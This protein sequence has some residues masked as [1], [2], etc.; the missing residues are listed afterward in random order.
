VLTI[1]LLG[2]AH[3]TLHGRTFPISAK[4]VALIT[5]LALEKVPQHRERLADLLWNTA[6]ARK[7]LRVELA[8]I[9]STGLN[10]FPASRQLLYL[11]NVVT[12]FELWRDRAGDDMNEIELSSWLTMLRGLPLSGLEDLGN[13]SFQEWVEQQRWMISQQVEQCLHSAYRRYAR[14]NHAWATRMIAARAE[15]LGLENPAGHDT[16]EAPAPTPARP[17]PAPTA[18]PEPERTARKGILHFDRPREEHALTASLERARTVPQA[19]IVHGEPGCGKTYLAEW[20]ARQTDA[21]TIRVTSTASAR[22]TIATL[23]QA[24]LHETDAEYASALTRVLLNPG[25]LDEDVVKVGAALASVRKPVLVMLD[26]VHQA[27]EDVAPLLEFLLRTPGS[28]ARAFLLLSREQPTHAPVT[29]LLAR[30]LDRTRYADVPLPPLTLAGVQR[31]LEQHFP[32]EPVKR[33]HVHANRLLQ[34][35]NGNP[36]RLLSLL[37]QG[38]DPRNITYSH[39][40]QL[41]RDKYEAETATWAKALHDAMSTLSVIVGSF[42]RATAHAALAAPEASDADAIIAEAITQRILAEVEPDATLQWPTLDVTPRGT[43]S[44]PQLMFT[45]EGLRVSLAGHLP[46]LTRRAICARLVN[47]YRQHQ[48]GLAAYYAERAGQSDEA[49]RLRQAYATLLP[50]GSPLRPDT[51]VLPPVSARPTAAEPERTRARAPR[52]PTTHNGYVIT[53]EDGQWLNIRSEGRYGHPAT[54]RVHLPLPAVNDPDAELTLTWRLDVYGD[55]RE[56]AP[57][58]VPFPL[59]LHAVGT[60]RAHVLTPHPTPSYAEDGIQHLVEDDAAVGTW[61]EYRLKLTAEERAARTLELSVR[62]PD[63][64]LTIGALRWSTQDLLHV[65]SNHDA[66]LTRVAPEPGLRPPAPQPHPRS[67]PVPHE[68]ARTPGAYQAKTELA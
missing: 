6:E 11:E 20:L 22:L 35:S 34:C 60:T 38:V 12:D 53:H 55:G 41:L 25:T 14:E 43:G 58:S 37:E 1:H 8:R 64:A 51:R 67:T 29:R 65:T 42:D 40:P 23:A 7:N 52:S 2:H 10:I 56:L 68:P 63:V 61:M 27:P 32:F 26:H 28:A 36:L 44:E 30:T 48:P 54:L 16:D 24:L 15:S 13:S 50:A 21:L 4:A 47:A 33:L 18:Q 19:I 31:A 46:Q 49:E 45:N 62:A 9:R 66:L 5:Y 59:R 17:T 39:I 57:T 3:V